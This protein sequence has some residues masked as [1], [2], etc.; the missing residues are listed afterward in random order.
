MELAEQE[1]GRVWKMIQNEI[2]EK[3]E[4]WCRRVFD[5]PVSADLSIM[6]EEQIEEAFSSDLKFGTAGLRGIM[7]AGTNRMNI[8]TVA[9]AS[10]GLADY[11]NQK[12]SPEER[13]IAV[14]RDSRN[15]SDLFGQTAAEVFS[16]NGIHVFY[17]EQIMP[18]PLLSYAVR[19]LGCAAGVMIT[20]SHNPPEYNG[21]KVYGAD[22][23]QIT[24][25]AAEAIQTAI[26]KTDIFDDVRKIP[27]ETAKEQGL[28]EYI[29]EEVYD[30]FI[31]TVKSQSLIGE[32]IPRDCG[33]V[34]SPLN[35]T[36]LF[37]VLRAL[38]E[39][40]YT[41]ITVVSEQEKP[42]GNFPT[43]RKPNPEEREALQLGLELADST[44]A[45][46]VMATDPDCD[47]IGISVR[48]G[49]GQFVL[50]T[51]NETGL[52]LLDYI[53]LRR[54]DSGTMPADPVMIKTIVT[55]DI[56]E[57][58]AEGYGAR[59]INVLTGFKYIGEKM[60]E[61][62]NEG[63]PDSYLIGFEE[64]YGYLTGTHVRDKDGVGTALM[65]CDMFAY[66]RAHDTSLLQRLDEIYQQY[67][68]CL[69]SVHSFQFE[70]SKGSFTMERIMNVLRSGVNRIG[71]F[72]VEEVKD[73]NTG[74][75]GLPP[76]NVL[77]FRL[78]SDILLTARPSGTEPKLKFYLSV[79]ADNRHSAERKEKQVMDDIEALTRI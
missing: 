36:G 28:I 17:Y 25:E 2:K 78:S 67:G 47:R 66:H 71:G 7:Q 23:C 24:S 39:S 75:E 37:P 1:S 20:A 27:F 26:G 57:R 70:G 32:E 76:S 65:I 77:Q 34:Y 21:Y 15:R 12:Y 3:Y 55:T 46:L 59:T 48:D 44:G 35:G 33:I 13:A 68:Y 40:G 9:R 61:L 5:G 69:N 73:Y 52:L 19:K 79:Y 63:K 54:L 43:C 22:G 60:T 58:V 42:D 74:I 56:A 45:D 14:S 30:S 31:E 72:N 11:I 50:L 53:C 18:V 64:S 10:Q 4:R 29:P 41:N 16:A 62:E 38:T 49:S 8:Y 51:G 6:K